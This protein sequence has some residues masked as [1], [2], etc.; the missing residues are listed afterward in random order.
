[1]T[2]CFGSSRAYRALLRAAAAVVPRAVA[3]SSP[4]AAA[5]VIADECVVAGPNYESD[6]GVQTLWRIV[7]QFCIPNAKLHG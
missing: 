7:L 3:A 5:R 1:M 2:S 4:P 6:I